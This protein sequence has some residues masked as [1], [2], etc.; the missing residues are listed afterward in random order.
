MG[1]TG[2]TTYSTIEAY[3]LLRDEIPPE[4]SHRVLEAIR[5]AAHFIARGQSEEDH[6]ANHHAMACLA[7]W[8]AHEL[9]GDPELKS[10]YEALW[11][12]FLGY[13]NADE[14]WS[15]EYDGPDPGY[16]SAIVSF[17]G[18]IYKRRPDPEML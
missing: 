18:K 4:V 6:L 12:G 10:S 1:P 16:L 17:L 11:Q 5:R 15:R 9:L 14:G 13:H 2:F 8:R 7:M 3:R